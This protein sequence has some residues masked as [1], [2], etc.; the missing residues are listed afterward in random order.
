[1]KLIYSSN[2]M[3]IKEVKFLKDRKNRKA[4]GQSFIE[5]IRIVEEA[6]LANAEITSLFVSIELLNPGKNFTGDFK[7]GETIEI[8][9]YIKRLEN[10]RLA[11]VLSKANQRG[12]SI[13]AIPDKLFK[14]ISATETPQGI[15]AVIPTKF[16]NLENI[17]E[18]TLEQSTEFQRNK[19]SLIILDGIQD[20]GNMGTIIRTAD[21]A[22]FNG[23]I[24]SKDCVDPYNP[25]VIRSTMGSIFYMPLYLSN[26]LSVTL[27]E[28]K[29]L[30]I[31]IYGA[32][33][34]GSVDY[35]KIDMTGNIAII[36]GNEA[37]GISSTSLCA[38]DKLIK[39]PM[40]GRL[41]SLNASVAAG[42]LIYESFRQETTLTK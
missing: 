2:N 38:A 26:N 1:M 14:S 22:G 34:E 18:R 19:I 30:G 29:D 31:K 13:Y 4:K 5:G 23:V 37:R 16:Y 20:P 9:K 28:I 17:I 33:L 6:L 8:E 24:L 35:Y 3:L 15:L 27:N 10:T 39:I 25:K 12:Y 36:I 7:G 21:G 32:H 11:S 42:I 40:P 41:E